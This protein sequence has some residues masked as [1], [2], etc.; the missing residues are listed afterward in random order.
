MQPDSETLEFAIARSIISDMEDP[1]KKLF[2]AVL[3]VSSFA[4]ANHH[5]GQH[6]GPC[7]ADAEKFCKD[8]QPGEGRIVKCLKEHESELSAECKAKKEEVKEEIK[9]KVEEVKEACAEDAKKFCADEKP[10]KGR[11]IKCLKKNEASVSEACKETLPGKGK[12]K[13]GHGKK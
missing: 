6:E 8:V 13:K 2:L 4:Y 5:E 10:G 12:W 3:F 7:K 9:G 11:I 1:M